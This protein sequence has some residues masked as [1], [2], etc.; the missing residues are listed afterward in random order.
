LR[1]VEFLEAQFELCS[2]LRENMSVDDD[3]NTEWL[4]ALA[5]VR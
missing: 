1:D 4:R 2:E 3:S 5:E